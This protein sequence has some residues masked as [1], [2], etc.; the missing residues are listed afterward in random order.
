MNHRL[1][2][3]SLNAVCAEVEKA[4]IIILVLIKPQKVSMPLAQQILNLIMYVYNKSLNAA[5]AA[6]LKIIH[7]LKKT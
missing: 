2:Y 1:F 5:R 6:N 7:N 3:S 4:K